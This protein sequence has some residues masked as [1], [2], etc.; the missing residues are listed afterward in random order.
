MSFAAT[1]ATALRALH[2]NMLRTIL[3]MLGII[4]GVAA[5]IVMVSISRG[6]GQ[7]IDQFI[8]TL[9]TNLITVQ[10]RTVSQDPRQGGEDTRVPFN[11]RDVAALRERVDGARAIAAMVR[12]RATVVGIGVNWPTS[13]I[14]SDEAYLEVRDWPLLE[15]R[16]LSASDVRSGAKVALIGQTV[17]TELFGGASPIDASIRVDGVPFRIVGL[18]GEKGQSSWGTDNDDVLIVP[19][20]TA[21]GRLVGGHDTVPNHVE[22]ILAESVDAATQTMVEEQIAE[23]LRTRRGIAPGGRDN[24]RVRN[25]TELISAR[26]QTQR[27]LGVLLAATAGV[28]LI[29][30]GIGIMNIM[31]VSVTERTREIGLRMAVGARRADIRAQFL[32][33]AICLC[34]IGGAIGVAL[35]AAGSMGVAS[36]AGWQGAIEVP[37]VMLALVASAGIGV[38][39][40]FFPAQR[41]AGLNPIEALRHE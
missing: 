8:N 38:V 18:L 10:P 17:A 6:A 3:A 21:R 34:G 35:G 23:T 20:T 4:I 14:G 29:V 13:L 30:G 37:V 24:F 22:T 39:F 5:V 25:L 27:T 16:N 40:G 11:D 32:T 15:G 9:G 41:A 19:I 31:L 2:A 7:Q 36:L 28:A 12:G 33:E 26:T 1:L